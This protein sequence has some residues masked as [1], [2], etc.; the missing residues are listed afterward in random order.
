MKA[1]KYVFVEPL[2]DDDARKLFGNIVGDLTDKCDIAAEIIK[3]CAGLPLAIRTIANALK[4][5]SDYVWRNALHQLKSS[6]PRCVPE[7]DNT[8]YSTIELSYALLNSE[9]AKSLLLLFALGYAGVDIGFMPLLAY[10]MGLGF[11]QDVYTIS[12]GISRIKSLIDYLEDSCLLL[13]GDKDG[14]VKMHDVIHHVVASIAKEKRMFHIQDGNGFEKVLVKRMCKDSIAIFLHWRDIDGLPERVKLPNLKLFT[15]CLCLKEDY[16]L[17]IPNHFFEGMKELKVLDLHNVHLLPL[18]SSFLCLTNLQTLNLLN[19]TL[20]D[21][22]MIGELRNLEILYFQSCEFEQLP[23]S[24]RQLT[25]LK[26]LQLADCPKLKVITPNVIASLSRLEELYIYNSFDRWEVEGQNNAS[27]AELKRL[28]QLNTLCIHIP[29]LQLIQ[30]DFIPENL[31]KYTVHIGDAWEWS[32][33]YEPSRT[34]RLK[35]NGSLHLRYGVEILVEKAKYLYLDQLDG[36]KDILWELDREGFPQLKHLS[37]QNSSEI[38]YIV[39]SIGCIPSNDGFPILESLFL[40]NLSNMEKI[41]CGLVD[42]TSFS[43]LRVL[44]V[45]RCDRL[46]YL[47]S[48]FM[49]GNISQIQEIEVTYCKKLKEIFSKESEDHVDENE[50]NSEIESTQ[51]HSLVLHCLPKFIHFGLKVCFSFSVAFYFI[52]L[53]NQ[54]FFN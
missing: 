47:F 18:P 21:I 8:L 24:F 51:L 49:A 35:F 13:K 53:K 28:S 34:L 54:V 22:T 5:K 32:H 12:D 16:F 38:L 15:L 19:C 45:E 36:V 9:E 52:L 43:K 44:K 23:E 30:Q 1:L 33:E 26:L 10:G 31:E 48:S 42:A 25:Q 4:G 17:Q 41:C 2:S 40:I 39:N 37:V 11:F 6:N 14:T 7:M 20:G 29:N 50:R 46:I 27:L 3:K